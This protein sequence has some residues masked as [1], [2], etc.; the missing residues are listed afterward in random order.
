MTHA[1]SSVSDV[2]PKQAPQDFAAICGL[3]WEGSAWYE[4]LAATCGTQ[5]E[6][7]LEKICPVYSCAKE[8]RV[9]HCG[10]C[11]EFPCLLLVHFAAQSRGDDIRIFS[12][13]RRAELGDE[14]WAAWARQ[15][16]MWRDAYCPLRTLQ[17]QKT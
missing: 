13:A 9:E 14:V 15:Q 5:G 7:G 6:A 17:V 1:E 10:L 16:R 11:P 8:H 3:Y 12:A 2:P 4:A